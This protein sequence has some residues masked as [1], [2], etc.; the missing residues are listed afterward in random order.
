MHTG[1]RVTWEQSESSSRR[2][3]D[4]P[5]RAAA[6]YLAWPLALFELFRGTQTSLW[7][8]AH[9]RQAAVL[10]TLC[11]VVLV[12][13][14]ALPLGIVLAL[15]GPGDGPT[16]AIYAAAMLLDVVVLAAAVWVSIRCAMRASR[17]EL[18]S[19]PLVTQLSER[20][21]LRRDA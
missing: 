16:I 19:L 12:L 2:E 18:F 6:A 10:G 14:L 7:Y 15:G 13:T 21:F 4:E 11:S 5:A 9:L 8:R 17:G 1:P 3:T 20:L